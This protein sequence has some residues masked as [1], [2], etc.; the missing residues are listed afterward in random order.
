MSSRAYVKRT[1]QVEISLQPN[2]LVVVRSFY[3]R[4]VVPTPNPPTHMWVRGGDLSPTAHVAA[5]HICQRSFWQKSIAAT[6]RSKLHCRYF[7]LIVCWYFSS[8]VSASNE[9]EETTSCRIHHFPTA[10]VAARHISK[11]SLLLISLAATPSHKVTWSGRKAH[12]RQGLHVVRLCRQR[13]FRPDL[14]SLTSLPHR[15]WS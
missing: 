6:P 11:R 8:F 14:L 10:H 3:K 9:L 2:C 1:V 7:S 5:M 13:A 15:A 12:C 4:K